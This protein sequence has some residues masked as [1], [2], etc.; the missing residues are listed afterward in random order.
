MDNRYRKLN[1]LGVKKISEYNETPEVLSGATPKMYYIVMVFDEVGDFMTRAKKE[2]EEKIRL[3]AAKSRACGIHL[4]LA[5]Q[6]PTVDVITGTIKANLPSRIAFAVNSVIDSKTILESS[7]AEYLL[8]MG[9]MLYL[10]Y[11]SNDIERIQ[12]CFVD[13]DELKAVIKFIKENNEAIYDE[14]IEDAMFNKR[15]AFDSG[16]SA[17]TAFDPMLKDCLKYF[18]RAKKASTSSLQSC[19]GIGYPKASKIVMQ[20]EKA[21]FVSMG[22]EKGRRTL[23]ITAQEFEE[24]FGEGI[25]D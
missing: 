17:D 2:I 7:G 15:D 14:E 1:A 21:G 9:D 24:R 3:L 19:F 25:D 4:I 18:I 23:F 11:G 8:G 12:G 22:D 16:N 5:T 20:M 13:N 6:R 10:P